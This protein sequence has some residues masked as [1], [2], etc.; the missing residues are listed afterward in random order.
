[1]R[2]WRGFAGGRAAREPQRQPGGRGRRRMRAIRSRACL[3]RK[4][5][6]RRALFLRA[7]EFVING[8]MGP[9]VSATGTSLEFEMEGIGAVDLRIG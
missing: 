9:Q 2:D 5:L 6:A 1:M 3:G 8:S 7:G 4:R